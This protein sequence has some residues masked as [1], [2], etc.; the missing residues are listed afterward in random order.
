M[1]RF[2]IIIPVAPYRNAEI[3]SS[4]KNLDYKKSKF[5]TIV[6]KGLNPSKNRN[7]A[8]KEAKSEYLVFLDDDAI[9]NPDYLSVLD[10]II[11]ECKAAALGG[12]QFTPK[13][14]SFFGKA[15]GYIFGSFLATY[16]MSNRYKRGRTKENADEFYFTSAN[17][18]IKKD[19]FLKIKGFNELL[20]PGEDP[21]FFSRL[22]NN[23]IKM[24][25]HPDII[26]YHRRRKNVSSMAKQFFL[27]G[28]VRLKKEK[29]SK[30]KSII[31][32]FP[33]LFVIYL[34][35]LPLLSIIP[36]L[37]IPLYFYLILIFINSIYLSFKHGFQYVFLFPLLFLLVH[38]SY[39]LG[40]ISSI[41]RK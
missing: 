6:K 20:F 13:N 19:I 17:F 28:Y 30:T 18:T 33:A 5:E 15:S 38:I 22:K 1:K 37:L 7:D 29:I 25:Y 9:I 26:I 27:Y 12:P 31:F 40:V 11:K 4:I 36:F 16:Q 32:F 34:L 8:A 21:E 2:S 35:F 3:L 41:I 10:K 24:L 14:D 23:N 39:G